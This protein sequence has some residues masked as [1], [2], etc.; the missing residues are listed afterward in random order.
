[1]G[2]KSEKLK[3]EFRAALLRYIELYQADHDI[4]VEIFNAQQKQREAYA[5]AHEQSAKVFD[6]W[7][8]VKNTPCPMGY[9]LLPGGQ[10][11]SIDEGRSITVWKPLII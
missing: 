7:K 6:L 2:Q 10:L 5:K 11:V 3:S 8:K 9:V 1:M 4:Q